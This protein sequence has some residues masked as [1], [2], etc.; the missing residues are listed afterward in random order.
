M[1][2]IVF[3]S[4]FFVFFQLFKRILGVIKTFYEGNKGTFAVETLFFIQKA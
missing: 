2:N 3:L 4:Q 1:G